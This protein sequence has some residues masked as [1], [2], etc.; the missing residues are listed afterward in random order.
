MNGKQSKTIQSS[1]IEMHIDHATKHVALYVEMDG[2]KLH[3]TWETEEGVE[4]SDYM[5]ESELR[6][7]MDKAW[8]LATA[9]IQ[10]RAA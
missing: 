8:R 6:T 3:R 1:S 2:E 5:Q 10:T 4:I 9:L 7:R